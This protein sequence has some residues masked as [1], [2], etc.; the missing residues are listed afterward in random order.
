L[1]CEVQTVPNNFDEMN[2]LGLTALEAGK[3]VVHVVS[4]ENN[5]AEMLFYRSHGYIPL[6]ISGGTLSNNSSLASDV[7][8]IQKSVPISV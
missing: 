3:R 2:G 7:I 1:Q 4:N 6:F 8:P 5:D